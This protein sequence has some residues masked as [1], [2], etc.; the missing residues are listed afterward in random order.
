MSLSAVRLA[1]MDT[2]SGI[3]GVTVPSDPLPMTILDKT[4]VVFPRIGDSELLSRGRTAG[5]IAIQ[6]HE[7]MQV[8]YHR[9]VPYEH[10]GST[11]GDITTMIETIS[12]LVWAEMAGGKFGGTI[13]SVQG[14]SL[15]HF[16]ALGW[17]E[18]TFGA[19]LGVNFTHV[20]LVS[21]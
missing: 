1:M 12:D 2:L 5:E 9:R 21:A 10:L 17:N 14:V 7:S 8:E 3:T 18:W 20:S 16:G 13:L 19:R 4:I 6:S 15:M 11:M